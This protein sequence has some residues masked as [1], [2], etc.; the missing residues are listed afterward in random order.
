LIFDLIDLISIQDTEN[1]TIQFPEKKKKM[2][3]KNDCQILKSK[4][5]TILNPYKN[6]INGTKNNEK[7]AQNDTSKAT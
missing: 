1:N 4:I 7:N 2:K 5:F 3:K 6:A